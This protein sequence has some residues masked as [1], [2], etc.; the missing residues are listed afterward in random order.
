MCS[1]KT[2]LKSKQQQHFEFPNTN[3]LSSAG[4]DA[5]FVLLLYTTILPKLTRTWNK[6]TMP[7]TAT[8]HRHLFNFP[9]YDPL[10]VARHLFSGPLHLHKRSTRVNKHRVWQ[11]TSDWVETGDVWIVLQ[12][13]MNFQPRSVS[14]SSSSVLLASRSIVKCRNIIDFVSVL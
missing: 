14:P 7:F 2:I 11:L 5:D 6:L 13:S 10:S 12:T 4:V 9:S 3:D 1:N 8:P